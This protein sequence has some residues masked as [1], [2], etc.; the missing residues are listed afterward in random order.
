MIN[1]DHAGRPLY[2]ER[3]APPHQQYF[4]SVSGSSKAVTKWL[5]DASG[6]TDVRP[7]A[8]SLSPELIDHY[9]S[10]M[11]GGAGTTLMRSS[12]LMSRMFTEPEKPLEPNDIPV[13]RRFIAGE[14]DYYDQ[15]EYYEMRSHMRLAKAALASDEARSRP[16]FATEIY[17]TEFKKAHF[18]MEVKKT[19]NQLSAIK[20]Q[21]DA[22]ANNE[23]LSKQQRHAKKEKLLKY[24]R[25]LITRTL[26]KARKQGVW[27]Q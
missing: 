3:E 21:I 13:L 7:G 24:R 1:E 25:T 23:S 19:D 15:N 20:R 27:P 8:I 9:T 22:L 10:F 12:K 17:P 14:A 6:G 26:Q 2:P 11:T 16:N 18:M 5:N 4:N